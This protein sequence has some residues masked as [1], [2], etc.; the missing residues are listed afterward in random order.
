MVSFKIVN[1]DSSGR[2][3]SL[4]EI[5]VSEIFYSENSLLIDSHK[6]CPVSKEIGYSVMEHFIKREDSHIIVLSTNGI[7]D[8]VLT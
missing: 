6:L 2:L 5:K 8:K 1:S 4:R 7:V 3:T